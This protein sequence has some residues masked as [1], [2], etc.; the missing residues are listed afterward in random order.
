M[1]QSRTFEE[2]VEYAKSLDYLARKDQ[3]KLIDQS[4]LYDYERI[5]TRYRN[6]KSLRKAK[7]I[8]GLCLCLR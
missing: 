5:E 2:W 3:W 7:D 1:E 6:M 4:R 8:K